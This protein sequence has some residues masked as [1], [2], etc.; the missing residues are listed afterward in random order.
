MLSKRKNK[1][2]MLKSTQRYIITTNDLNSFRF[3][4]LTDGLDWKLYKKNSI[5]LFMHYRATGINTSEYK[6]LGSVREIEIDD[7][8]VVT[9]RLYFNDK[10]PPAVEMYDAYENGT[11]NMLSIGVEPIELSDDPEHMLPGQCGCTVT[12]G[13][14]KEISCVDIG[15]NTEACAVVLYDPSGKMI[16]LSDQSLKSL[17]PSKTEKVNMKLL[18]LS[19]PALLAILKLADTATEAEANMAIQNLVTLAD[20]QATTIQTLT[21]EKKEADDKAVKLET[22]LAAQVKLALDGKIETL[23]QGAIDNRKITADQ[24]QHFVGLAATSY[25]SVEKILNGMTGTPTVKSQ[26]SE[27]KGDKS[28]MR[29]AELVKLSFDVLFNNGGLAELK[30]LD[31]AAYETKKSEKFPKA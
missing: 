12:K 9:G 11:Y 5:L 4:I 20:S 16:T 2:Q 30:K 1:A 14:V 8:G 21:G 24:K 18:T 7:N 17:I 25:D 31:L 10:Y 26:L 29:I 15:A 23:V 27:D 13:I 22:D 19:A 3:R 6:A 28:A